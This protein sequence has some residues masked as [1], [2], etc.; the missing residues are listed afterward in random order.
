M[1]YWVEG[2]IPTRLLEAF[3]QNVIEFQK[4]APSVEITTI[5][6][7]CGAILKTVVNPSPQALLTLDLYEAAHSALNHSQKIME[8]WTSAVAFS[9]VGQHVTSII[10]ELQDPQC[11]LNRIVQAKLKDPTA[12]ESE[13]SRILMDFYFDKIMPKV[14]Q[15][16]V[17]PSHEGLETLGIRK[18]VK[19][20]TLV[21][22]MVCWLIVHGFDPEDI[23]IVPS[24]LR[25]SRAPVYIG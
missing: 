16:N 12:I 15:S 17:E 14:C 24:K 19:W 8:L 18:D 10:N 3:Q 22:R 23:Q 13:E 1:D 7:H 5:L 2:F 9:I 25:Y 4:K 21:F 11:P 20:I 6:E